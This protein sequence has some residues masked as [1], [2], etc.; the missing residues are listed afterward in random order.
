MFGANWPWQGAVLTASLR[1]VLAVAL[2]Y[3]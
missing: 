3:R 1:A 2:I